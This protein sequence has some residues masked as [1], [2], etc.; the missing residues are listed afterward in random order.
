M[1]NSLHETNQNLSRR[2]V[3]DGYAVKYE[4]RKASTLL[5][6][7][8]ATALATALVIGTGATLRNMSPDYQLSNATTTVTT[9]VGDTLYSL[10]NDIPGIEHID[11]RIAVE[12]IKELN[13]DTIINDVVT[14]YTE[15][16]VPASIVEEGE[17]V[18]DTAVADNN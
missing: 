7:V 1:S 10:A 5:K 4:K 6:R 13:P 16:T 18:D 14:P 12:E 17:I 9:D 2:Y 11:A 3:L 15:V 8:G